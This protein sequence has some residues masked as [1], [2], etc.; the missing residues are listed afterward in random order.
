MPKVDIGSNVTLFG[1]ETGFY[2]GEAN[3][4]MAR[5][6]YPNPDDRENYDQDFLANM[7][8]A[9]RSHR[10]VDKN[11]SSDPQGIQR[12]LQLLSKAPVNWEVCV[13]DSREEAQLF[14][15]ESVGKAGFPTLA[16]TNQ[17]AHWVLVVGWETEIPPEGGEPVVKHIRYYDPEPIGV[18]SDITVAASTWQRAERFSKVTEKGTWMGKFVAIGQRP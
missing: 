17:G 18:G 16:L 7:I 3:T 10:E 1:Q 13:S 8:K 9:H 11:W 6:G 14:I 5:F 4:Q 15:Q 12:C 2:C